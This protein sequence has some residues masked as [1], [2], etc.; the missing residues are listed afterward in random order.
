MKLYIIA[1]FIRRVIGIFG[2]FGGTYVFCRGFFVV[3]FW[4]VLFNMC[5]Q[6]VFFLYGLGGCNVLEIFQIG[7]WGFFDKDSKGM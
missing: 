7:V 1:F 3:G 5:F 2:D 4:D 6:S